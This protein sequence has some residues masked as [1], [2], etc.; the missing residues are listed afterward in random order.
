MRLQE[1]SILE[2]HTTGSLFL[3]VGHQ[4]ADAKNDFKGKFPIEF[5]TSNNKLQ[6]AVRSLE[7]IYTVPGNLKF[8]IHIVLIKRFGLVSQ[9]QFGNPNFF[10]LS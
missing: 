9:E 10:S 5:H 4:A 1:I 3:G 2:N 7:L 6:M 8:P